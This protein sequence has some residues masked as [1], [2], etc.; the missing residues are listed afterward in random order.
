MDGQRL[1]N[2]PT[3]KRETQPLF[4]DTG[5]EGRLDLLGHRAIVV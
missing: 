4:S 1:T 3:G 5:V 2:R